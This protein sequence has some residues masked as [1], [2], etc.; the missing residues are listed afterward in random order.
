MRLY[1]VPELGYGKTYDVVVRAIVNGKGGAYGTVCQ[2]TV[3][4][5][6]T[7]KLRTGSCGATLPDLNSAIYWDYI[8]GTDDYEVLFTDTD[9]LSQITYNRG[10]YYGMRLFWASGLQGGGKTYDVQ[11]RAIINGTQGS[12]GPVCQ[13]TITGGARLSGGENM[14][15]INNELSKDVA[16]Q[17]YPNPSDGSYIYINFD[18]FNE[19]NRSVELT[20]YDI[21]GKKVYSEEVILNKNI[22]AGINLKNKLVPG[23]YILNF[24]VNG[25]VW[26]KKLIIK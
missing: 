6:P 24:Y 13:I 9:D 19:S 17:V 14:L 11:V 2:V 22:T 20:I 23:V 21:L 18:A 26:H 12:Y 7:T 5:I 15:S 10:P 3:Q 25:K 16:L 4:T 8:I 1:W